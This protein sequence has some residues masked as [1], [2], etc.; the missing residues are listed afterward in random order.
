MHPGRSSA[1]AS[2]SASVCVIPKDLIPECGERASAR[3][4]MQGVR[5]VDQLRAHRE[6]ST[7][8]ECGGAVIC[9]YARYDSGMIV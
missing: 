5:G 8:K 4:P 7:C 3:E 2:P 9:P 6:R 1:D